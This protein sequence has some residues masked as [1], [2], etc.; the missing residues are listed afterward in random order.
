MC[1][2]LSLR[3]LSQ[4]FLSIFFSRP[5]C[6][7]WKLLAK[8][9]ELTVPWPGSDF[10]VGTGG[11]GMEVP[12]RGPGTEPRWGSTAKPPWSQIYD[13]IRTICSSQ[14]VRIIAFL[15]R[16]DAESFLHIL[17]PP[18]PPK[19]KPNTAGAGWARVVTGH[20]WVPTRVYATESKTHFDAFWNN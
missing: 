9:W 7:H 17:C 13:S 5:L 15:C 2:L 3:P 4:L 6:K 14:K 19:K 8:L 16:F 12:Q 1:R 18:P 10:R 20:G 11:L